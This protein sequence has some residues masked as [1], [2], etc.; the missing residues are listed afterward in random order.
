[1]PLVRPHLVGGRIA[2]NLEVK[3]I[4]NIDKL[5]FKI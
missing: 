5:I 1:M 2:M 4:N 3:T